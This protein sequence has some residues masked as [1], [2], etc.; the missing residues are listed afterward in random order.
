M[1]AAI[2]VGCCFFLSD[3]YSFNSPS[4]CVVCLHLL[5][6]GCFQVYLVLC[7]P[8]EYSNP[9]LCVIPFDCSF[10]LAQ[11]FLQH[12]SSFSNVHAFSTGYL[13]H[14]SFFLPRWLWLLRLY[15]GFAECSS[16]LEG[17]PNPQWPTRPFNPLTHT[18][19][20][21]NDSASH[22]MGLVINNLPHIVKHSILQSAILT[23]STCIYP[24]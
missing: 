14:N 13:S 10:V 19:V 8:C 15:Q 16:R 24:G 9:I 18:T 3:V 7:L 2:K 1:P 21:L 12:S 22:R 6:C 20:S 17:C 5:H 4:L 11:C 23:E